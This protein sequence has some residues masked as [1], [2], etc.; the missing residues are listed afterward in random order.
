MNE[1]SGYS[2]EVLLSFVL[3]NACVCVHLGEDFARKQK[4]SDTPIESLNKYGTSKELNWTKTGIRVDISSSR[5]L[6]K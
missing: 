6:V 2:R 5:Y 4:R 3:D 1:A